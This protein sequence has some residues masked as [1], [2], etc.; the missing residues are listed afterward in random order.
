MEGEKTMESIVGF[1]DGGILP[2]LDKAWFFIS[3]S[4]RTLLFFAG[5]LVLIYCFWDGFKELFV[6]PLRSFIRKHTKWRE[7]RRFEYKGQLMIGEKGKIGISRGSST[8]FIRNQRDAYTWHFWNEWS[9]FEKGFRIVGTHPMHKEGITLFEGIPREV[10]GSPGIR[11]VETIMTFPESGIWK[12][13]MY[14]WN[15]R[16]GTIYL[17]VEDQ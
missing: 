10:S 16:R 13:D 15:I 14:L 5:L 12:V 17:K 9:A 8:R 11:C 1:V 7:C 2:L 3:E 4:F 6:S